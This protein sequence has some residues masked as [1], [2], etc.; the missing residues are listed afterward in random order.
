VPSKTPLFTSEDRNRLRRFISL[1]EA[2]LAREDEALAL[3]SAKL[4]RGR[5]TE[6]DN[7]PDDLVTMHSQVRMRDADTGRYYV[8]TVSLPPD[9]SND[10]A[11]SLLHVYPKA[12]LLGARV[13]D[14]IVWR[15]AGRLR[16]AR[17]EQLL[18][19]PEASAR[20]AQRRTWGTAWMPLSPPRREDSYPR[21][22]RSRRVSGHSEPA[23]I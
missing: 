21:E 19:Q 5:L 11:G 22:L 17:I 10:W 13:G 23:G 16:R 1:H 6:T 8:T 12:A 4:E 7:V 3:L 14:D 18:F 9:R 20:R 2:R 15:F